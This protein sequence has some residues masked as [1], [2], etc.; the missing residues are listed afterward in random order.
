MCCAVLSMLA[1][2]GVATSA[3]ANDSGIEQ[4]RRTELIAEVGGANMGD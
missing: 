1:T 2:G 4:V 3:L